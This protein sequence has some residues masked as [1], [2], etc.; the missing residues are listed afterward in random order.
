MT[1]PTWAA[2]LLLYASLG[3]ADDPVTMRITTPK[4][5]VYGTGSDSVQFTPFYFKTPG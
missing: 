1:P 4:S 3:L 5:K 2:F